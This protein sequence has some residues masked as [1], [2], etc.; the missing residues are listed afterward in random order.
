MTRVSQISN[1][2]EQGMADVLRVLGR[3]LASGVLTRAEHDAILAAHIASTRP[4]TIEDA[5]AGPAVSPT[6]SV[7][8]VV[9]PSIL[10]FTCD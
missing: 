10:L 5:A 1:L 9:E 8:S 4:P 3:K 6:S 2:A 7:V